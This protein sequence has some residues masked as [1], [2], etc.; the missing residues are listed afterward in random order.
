M[1]ALCGVGYEPNTGAEPMPPKVL[2]PQ[3]MAGMVQR[4]REPDVVSEEFGSTST[5]NFY[6]S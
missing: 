1:A 3:S 2:F 4:M 6:R 5:A